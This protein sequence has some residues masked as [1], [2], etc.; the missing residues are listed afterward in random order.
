MTASDPFLIPV[1]HKLAN[2]PELRD[3]FNFLGK[4]LHDLTATPGDVISNVTIITIAS[5]TVITD[6]GVSVNLS[7]SVENLDKTLD[8]VIARV[9]LLE[10]TVN[11]VLAQMRLDRDI[12]TS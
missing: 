4:V 12:K 9:K 11:A 6:I 7:T 10:T 5:A 8:E 1:P 2:D 3:Y